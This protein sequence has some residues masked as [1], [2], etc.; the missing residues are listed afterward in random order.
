MQIFKNR[1]DN[2]NLYLQNVCNNHWM[3]PIYK[4]CCHPHVVYITEMLYLLNACMVPHQ[5][6]NTEKKK[7]VKWPQQVH[8]QVLT[9]LG[10]SR[11]IYFLIDT[12]SF[13][14]MITSASSSLQILCFPSFSIEYNVHLTLYSK[15][16]DIT[17]Q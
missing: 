11:C 6:V 17:V 7:I 8:I 13:E 12:F 5:A 14:N 15:D 2:N 16:R 3:L 10:Q 9:F 1:F 4:H